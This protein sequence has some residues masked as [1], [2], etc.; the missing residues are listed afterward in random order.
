MSL[1]NP[2]KYMAH[3]ERFSEE[4]FAEVYENAKGNLVLRMDYRLDET[5]HVLR[6]YS[7]LAVNGE[8]R[9]RTIEDLKTRF[10]WNGLDPLWFET[11][12][13]AHVQ[14][15]AVVEDEVGRDGNTY[16]RLRWINTPGSH[17]G[18]EPRQV[19]RRA[20][21]AKYG[22]LFRA[23]AGPQPT[24]QSVPQ[25]APSAPA[26]VAPTAPPVTTVR[27]STLQECWERMLAATRDATDDDRAKDWFAIQKEIAPS[28]TQ[29]DFTPVDWGH[30]L[31]R[32]ERMASV[33]TSIEEDNLPY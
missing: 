19:D 11:A 31:A 3:P 17:G 4:K 14:V 25:T 33:R 22:S 26:P 5:G 8:I 23:V 2:G 27:P 7:T 15:E 28:K 1:V 12:D 13:L 16:S 32:I 30:I 9:Q 6:H 20:I 10:G 18:N 29:D 24:P 21:Q